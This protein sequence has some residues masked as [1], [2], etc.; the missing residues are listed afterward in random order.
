[1]VTDKAET[2]GPLRDKGCSHLNISGELSILRTRI[3]SSSVHIRAA[4]DWGQ[5]YEDTTYF[6]WFNGRDSYGNVYAKSYR[7]HWRFFWRGDRLAVI[8]DGYFLWYTING[9][10]QSNYNPILGTDIQIWVRS[11]GRLYRGNQIH[12][13]RAASLIPDS[14]IAALIDA[15]PL[16]QLQSWTSGVTSTPLFPNDSDMVSAMT[17]AI[18]SFPDWVSLVQGVEPVDYGLLAVECAEQL[19]YVDS[20]VLLLALD[21]DDWRRIHSTWKTIANLPGWKRAGKALQR[22]ATGASSSWY[23]LVHILKPGAASYLFEK[24]AIETAVSDLSRLGKGFA[25]FCTYKPLHQRLH[26]RRI[27][28]LEPSNAAYRR[29]TGVLSVDTGS[30]PD[31]VSGFIQAY[32]GEIK[33]WG[34]YPE[35]TNLWDVV[36][37]SFVVDWTVNYGDL[38]KQCD[39]YLNT[40][41]YFPVDRCIMSAKWEAGYSSSVVMPD[42]PV[43]GEI[44]YSH[45]R[46][47]ITREVPLPD[48]A[49]SIGSGPIDHGVE[50]G[51]LLL[52]RM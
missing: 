16:G 26:S 46:R 13:A 19:D 25:R 50:T 4:V 11:G 3:Q 35:L 38:L 9:V 2:C 45:Y 40:R 18:E 6:T 10:S 33:R 30:Y 51:A 44:V 5:P 52:Q 17:E 28:E 20:N 41:N 7:Q 48:V 1:M 36:P 39:A 27:V 8:K 49:L 32:I 21:I 37:Y 29:F 23:D 12:D 15:A 22:L 31:G 47:W 14:Y 34:I 42:L 24:Y 43:T